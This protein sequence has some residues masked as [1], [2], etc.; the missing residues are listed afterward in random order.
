MKEKKMTHSAGNNVKV[1]K[2]KKKAYIKVHHCD[3]I[4]SHWIQQALDQAVNATI[5]EMTKESE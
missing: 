2:N 1:S 4:S 3:W 5:V